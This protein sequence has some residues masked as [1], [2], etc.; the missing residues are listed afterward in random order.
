[1]EIKHSSKGAEFSLVLSKN[2]L[3]TRDNLAKRCWCNDGKN[4]LQTRD[5]GAI[6]DLD[7]PLMRCR[8]MD[9]AQDGRLLN[10]HQVEGCKDAK[11]EKAFQVVSYFPAW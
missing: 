2:K 11:S 10:L 1:L 5:A 6:M 4:E 8:S 9:A 7:L 3:L